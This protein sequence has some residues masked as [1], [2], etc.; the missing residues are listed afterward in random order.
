[1]AESEPGPAPETARALLGLPEAAS[2]EQLEGAYLR[3]R[4]HIEHRLQASRDEGFREARRRELEALDAATL[5]CPGIDP[6]LVAAPAPAS[7]RTRVSRWLVAWAALATA[8]AIVLLILRFATLT[9]PGGAPGS[10]AQEADAAGAARLVVSADPPSARLTVTT[11]EDARVV[12]SS[13]ADGQAIAL[14]PGAYALAVSHPDC[15]DDWSQAATLEAGETRTYAPTICHGEGRLVVRSNVSEDR[16]RIDGVDVGSTGATPRALRTGAHEVRVEKQGFEPW[17]GEVRIEPGGEITLNAELVA[18]GNGKKKPPAP[19]AP[20]SPP[21]A[22]AAP[23][24][25]QAPAPDETPPEGPDVAGGLIDPTRG[26]R[27]MPARTGKGGSKSWHDAIKADL[28]SQF[29]RNG[30]GSLD[31]PAEVDAISCETWRNIEK[32]YETGGLAVAMTHLYGFDGSEAP[33]NTLGVALSVR[34]HAYERMK[35]CGLEARR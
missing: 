18:S 26:G 10:A 5:A 13:A 22:A 3:L 29:D 19:A 35:A 15:P 24:R 33:A 16:V 11:G 34:D 28:I 12:A 9:G 4:A 14:P 2:P 30:S 25:K 6:G 1:M 7:R 8:A 20:P 32:S 31:T 23:G 17:V 27:P 21:V